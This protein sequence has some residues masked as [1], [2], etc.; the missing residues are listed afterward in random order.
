MDG[1]KTAAARGAQ[2]RGESGLCRIF[3]FF[4]GTHEPG[5]AGT[6]ARF[7]GPFSPNG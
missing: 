5:L 4:A 3:G 2:P 6:Q 7:R 1:G